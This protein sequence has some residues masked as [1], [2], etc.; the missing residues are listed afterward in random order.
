MTDFRAQ[1]TAQRDEVGPLYAGFAAAAAEF[2]CDSQPGLHLQGIHRRLGCA[3]YGGLLQSVYR[4]NDPFGPVERGEVRG[5][6]TVEDVAGEA[7]LVG[8]GG[9]PVQ[10]PRRTADFVRSGFNPLRAGVFV[11]N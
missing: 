9:N 1:R 8:P 3:P 11:E 5:D 6:E 4:L 7:I 10:Y 2:P